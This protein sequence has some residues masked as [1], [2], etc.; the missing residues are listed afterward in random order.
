[1]HLKIIEPV[2]QH[3]S[4]RM[5]RVAIDET[6]MRAREYFCKLGLPGLY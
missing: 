5:L 3:S 4:F 2:N 1:M 6:R